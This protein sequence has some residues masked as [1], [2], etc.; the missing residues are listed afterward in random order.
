MTLKT[1]MATENSAV[2]HI[3]DPGPQ[4]QSLGYIFCNSQKNIVWVKIINFP[5]MPKIIRI[6]SKDHI[7]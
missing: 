5:F 7:P 1:V 2:H 6:L 3:C 4:N